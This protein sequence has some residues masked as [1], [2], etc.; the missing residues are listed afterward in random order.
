MT[1]LCESNISIIPINNFNEGERMRYLS[2]YGVIG[3]MIFDNGMRAVMYNI[4]VDNQ[5]PV[6]VTYDNHGIGIDTLELFK[7]PCTED[8]LIRYYSAFTIKASGNIQL[9]INEIHTKWNEEFTSEISV[10]T[11]RLEKKYSIDDEGFFNPNK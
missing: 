1:I 11:I 5:V 3:R 6:L 7:M 8:P 4:A 2:Y 9:R 10:D